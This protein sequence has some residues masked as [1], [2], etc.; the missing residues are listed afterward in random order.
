MRIQADAAKI[1]RKYHRNP[2]NKI[3]ATSF[4]TVIGMCQ[5]NSLKFVVQPQPE[6]VLF[7]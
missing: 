6:Q 2:E 3:T 5:P 1:T 7:F 4:G